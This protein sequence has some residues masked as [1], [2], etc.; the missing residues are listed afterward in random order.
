MT[1]LVGLYHTLIFSQYYF[2]IPLYLSIEVSEIMNQIVNLSLKRDRD[3]IYKQKVLNY[4]FLKPEYA[5]EDKRKEVKIEMGNIEFRGVGL[6]YG[7]NLMPVLKN[8]TF[9]IKDGEKI[10]ILGKPGSGK[11]SIFNLIQG[12]NR[13]SEGE[14]FLNNV[15]LR[16]ISP[17]IIRRQSCMVHK[18]CFI[19]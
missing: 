3:W 12:F 2:F 14:I 1:T 7:K 18:E 5:S 4:S 19:L 6:K 17:K 13:P 16:T 15:N 9:N 11:S 8:M 10:A